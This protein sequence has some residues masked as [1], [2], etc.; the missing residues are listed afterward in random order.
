MS[1]VVFVHPDLVDVEI[2]AAKKLERPE[3]DDPDYMKYLADTAAGLRSDPW[4]EDS[5]VFSV[6]PWHYDYDKIAQDA[7]VPTK[8]RY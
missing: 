2:E 8:Q 7:N 1:V 5:T 3:Y 4:D 6:V